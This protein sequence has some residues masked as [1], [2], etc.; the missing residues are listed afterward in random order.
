MLRHIEHLPLSLNRGAVGFLDVA[1]TG[2]ESNPAHTV[3][4]VLGIEAV[5]VACQEIA[6]KLA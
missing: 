2:N 6:T 5:L 3:T 4:V 1:N